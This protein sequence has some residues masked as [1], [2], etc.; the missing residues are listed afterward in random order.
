M[1]IV[2]TLG[3]LERPALPPTHVAPEDGVLS[4][5]PMPYTPGLTKVSEKP[6]MFVMEGFL[7]P[8]VGR[9]S[10]S[11]RRLCLQFPFVLPGYVRFVLFSGLFRH[12]PQECEQ[13]KA[14]A[15]PTLFPSIVV[16]G[17]EGRTV[18]PSRTSSSCFLD[19]KDTVWLAEKVQ[20]LTGKVRR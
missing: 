3:S 12:V 14:T 11:F 6:P 8:E 17:V 1:S 18:F 19:K 9:F 5:L 7:S 10:V 2:D 15:S 13:L 4:Y 16:D 20:A